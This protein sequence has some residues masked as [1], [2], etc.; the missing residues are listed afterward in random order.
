MIVL[1]EY[2]LLACG[3]IDLVSVA[4]TAT[5]ADESLAAAYSIKACGSCRQNGPAK[6]LM[7]DAAGLRRSNK[8]WS[9]EAHRDIHGEGFAKLGRG[10]D[11]L[12]GNAEGAGLKQARDWWE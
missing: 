7:Q 4:F 11:I 3:T 10:Q 1:F 2:P 8:L 6:M 9:R 5:A 12:H